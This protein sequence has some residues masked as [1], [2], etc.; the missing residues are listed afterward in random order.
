MSEQAKFPMPESAFLLGVGGMGMAPLAIFLAQAG[1]RVSG[2]DDSMQTPVRAL[3]VSNGVQLEQDA[4]ETVEAEAIV[5]S[6][7]IDFEHPLLENGRRAGLPVLRRGEMLAYLA[8]KFNLVAVAGSHGKTTTTGMLIHFLRQSGQPFHYVLGARFR[9]DAYPPARFEPGAKWLVAEVDESDGT[10]EAFDPE[11]TVFVNFDW[12]H[13]DRYAT[14]G[15]LDA[16]FARLAQRTH[17]A[18]FAPAHTVMPLDTLSDAEWIP[19]PVSQA[20]FNAS[21]AALAHA[22]AEYIA[23]DDLDASLDSFP[24]I[25]RRQDVLYQDNDTVLVADYAHHP[26]EIDALISHARLRWP[27]MLIAVFQPHRY[28]RTAIFARDFAR[29]LSPADAV[30]L[31]P[32][33]AASE[34]PREDGL[35]TAILTHAGSHWQESTADCLCPVLD[36]F[37][38]GEEQATV[39]F[40]GAGDIDRIAT[41]Y[42]TH[43]QSLRQRKEVRL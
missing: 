42:A 25:A 24:G 34:Q 14:E 28:S 22:A 32:V 10:I 8:R 35:S 3:L 40:I 18:L 5:F 31:L 2:W 27:G 16:A 26:T 43:W 12:D 13:A 39:L 30:I 36:Q 23:D 1:C 29:V 15:E 37:L 9:D 33:Y 4:P 21:N 17:R 38:G 20:D 7:A 19:V 41:D 6:S 11:L